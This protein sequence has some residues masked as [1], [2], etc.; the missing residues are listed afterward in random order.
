MNQIERFHE[1]WPFG[2]RFILL[3][4][5]CAYEVGHTERGPIFRVPVTVIVPIRLVDSSFFI[6]FFRSFFLL[7]VCFS[8]TVCFLIAIAISLVSIK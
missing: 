1:F 6:S 8:V 2:N 5:V 3:L 7:F 4:Q